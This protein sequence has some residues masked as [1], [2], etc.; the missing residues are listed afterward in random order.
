MIIHYHYQ[1]NTKKSK[2]EET[3]KAFEENK[4]ESYIKE[5]NQKVDP[6]ERCFLYREIDLKKT[7]IIIKK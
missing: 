3:S 1:K 7:A 4:R 2:N 6:I 5:L